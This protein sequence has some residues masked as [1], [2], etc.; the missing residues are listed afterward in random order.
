MEIIEVYETPAV[1]IIDVEKLK[2]ITALAGS[3]DKHCT[4]R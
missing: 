3:C 4:G 1:E 2:D